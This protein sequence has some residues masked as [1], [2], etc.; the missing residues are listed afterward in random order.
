MWRDDFIRQPP[1]AS[2]RRHLSLVVVWHVVCVHMALIGWYGGEMTA[3]LSWQWLTPSHPAG[4]CSR[5]WWFIIDGCLGLFYLST[6]TSAPICSWDEHDSPWL[7][8]GDPNKPCDLRGFSLL[9]LM[10]EAWAKMGVPGVKSPGERL[11]GYPG[12][13]IRV[14]AQN[15]CLA[16]KSSVT[17]N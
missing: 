1:P 13:S 14:W 6:M 10:C 2:P 8:G 5:W 16:H 17:L 9:L 4:G 15:E 3:C 12:T 11:R 7:A